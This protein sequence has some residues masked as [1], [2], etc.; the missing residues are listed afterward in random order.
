MFG[1][2]DGN[3]LPDLY[4][5][6]NNSGALLPELFY[7]NLGSGAFR[8]EALA[9]GIANLDTGSHGGV[10]A[11]LDN[12]GDLDLFNGSFEQNRLYRNDGTGAFTDVTVAAGLPA[13]LWATRGSLAF[14]MD[15]DGDLD[16]FAVNG[17]LG[18]D[19]PVGERNE[20]YRNDGAFRFTAIDSGALATA[21]AG[22]GAT[23]V[24]FDNDGDVDV[25]AANRTGPVAVLRNDGAGAFTQL[26]A[27]ALGLQAEGRDGI[28]FADVDNDGRLDV[29]L[30]QAL[31]LR[32]AAGGYLRQRVFDA[33]TYHYMGGFADLDNDGDFDLVFPGANHVYVNDGAG[34]FTASASFALGTVNDPR[35]VAFA[36][37]EQD[38]DLDFLYAQKFASNRLVENQLVSVNRWLKIDLRG[39]GGQRTPPGA[40]VYLYEAGGLGDPA[41]RIT[42]WELR[43]QDGYL[44]Q[45]DGIVHLGVGARAQV[46]LRAVFLGGATV[47]LTNV[48][49][50]ASVEVRRP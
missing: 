41:R 11:D 42:W 22:Q 29:L 2:V 7:L 30:S 24:D 37:I 5:T 9:R 1:D 36:D 38:G 28:S 3:G 14:D 26:D 12:D 47:E 8:E 15:N 35:S 33:A 20:V 19:D 50:N 23:A 48:P 16:L 4:V 46:D 39:A 18:N 43:S 34:S 27:S 49:T 25:F 32:T 44:S 6:V 31:Y 45:T 40:R 21:L 17:F 10:W 13:R